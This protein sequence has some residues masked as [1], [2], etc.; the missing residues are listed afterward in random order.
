MKK[1][2]EIFV[3]LLM[4]D[5][6]ELY[7]LMAEN[8]DI[9]FVCAA[10]NSRLNLD[11]ISVYPACYD[12]DNVISVMA[13]DNVGEIYDVSGYGST[14]DIAAPG[15]DI[16]V[17]IPEG[18]ETYVDGTS[19]AAAFVSATSALMKSY[20]ME[21]SPNEMKSIIIETAQKLDSL[22]GM[23]KSE[24]CVDAYNALRHCN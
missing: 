22:K 6:T 7:K 1:V 16:L 13:I 23:C 12:L 18:D 10:G 3:S 14:V 11:E 9:L 5:E 19:I 20:N 8:K 4:D 17:T 15:K 2:R 21:L 24:G